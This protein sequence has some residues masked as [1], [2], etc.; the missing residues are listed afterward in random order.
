[1]SYTFSRRT[2]LKTS[3]VLAMAAATS[4]LLSGCEYTDPDNPVSTKIGTTL[5]IAQTLGTLNSYDETTG[6]FNFT[7]ESNYDLP[8]L[9]EPGR[10]AVKVVDSLGT[11][12][13]YSGNV[14][15]VSLDLPVDF[16]GPRLNSDDGELTLDILAPSFTAPEAG[17]SVILQYIPIR[18][19]SEY[20]M[21]WKLTKEEEVQE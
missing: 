8:L 12:K 10:F 2:F 18:E 21:S 16:N 7:I 17:E 19:K 14:G 6:V 11:P 5:E 13:Y 3:A 9:V 4:G 20:S 1:M 15:G